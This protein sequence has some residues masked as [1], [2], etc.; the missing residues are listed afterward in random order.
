MPNQS[1]NV[2]FFISR[3]GR[4]FSV[5]TPPDMIEAPSRAILVCIH[6][7]LNC[8]H[9]WYVQY[10]NSEGLCFSFIDPTLFGGIR[11][12]GHGATSRWAILPPSNETFILYAA[13][14]FFTLRLWFYM[15]FLLLSMFSSKFLLLFFQHLFIK[16]QSK[17]SMSSI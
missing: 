12:I 3:C 11:K 1:S 6:F 7:L 9:F 17:K 14:R 8:E 10:K 16:S 4:A 2:F 13:H 5:N 15:I